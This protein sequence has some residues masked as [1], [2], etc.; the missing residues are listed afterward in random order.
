M[1][2]VDSCIIVASYASVSKGTIAVGRWSRGMGVTS[3]SLVIPCGGGDKLAW[4]C[5]VCAVVPMGMDCSVEF[6]EGGG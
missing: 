4:V 3:V 1:F 6:C 2:R 5:K